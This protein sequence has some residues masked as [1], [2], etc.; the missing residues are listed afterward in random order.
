MIQIGS[1]MHTEEGKISCSLK[2]SDLDSSGTKTSP[3][4]APNIPAKEPAPIPP[5][6][7]FRSIR[8]AITPLGKYSH[9]QRKLYKKCCCL[10]ETAAPYRNYCAFRTRSV[11][12]KLKSRSV[13]GFFSIIS[14]YHFS[15]FSAVIWALIM[16]SRKVSLAKP[17]K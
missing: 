9:R 3:P 8:N 1:M 6:R 13:T 7:V 10:V 4:P 2:C 14:E 5:R 12:M 17:E 11:R 16:C 15:D